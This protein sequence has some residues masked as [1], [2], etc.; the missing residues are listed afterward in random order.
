MEVLC[1]VLVLTSPAFH[2]E[3]KEACFESP[4]ACIIAESLWRRQGVQTECRPER[5]WVDL[6]EQ[7]EESSPGG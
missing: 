4:T 3:A 1:F 5:W 7:Q 6:P 2:T